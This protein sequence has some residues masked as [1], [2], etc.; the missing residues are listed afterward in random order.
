MPGLFAAPLEVFG[1]VPVEEH[2][3]FP[4]CQAVF[5]AGE[6]Q[7]IHARLP[8]DLGG[9]NVQ[10]GHG[11]G[12]PGTV[13]VD[14]QPITIRYSS[15]GAKLVRCVDRAHLRRLGQAESLGLGVV[16]I[17]ALGDQVLDALRG[18]F[19]IRPIAQ[20]QLGAIG[21]IFWPA[22]FIRFDVCQFV[23]DHAVEGLTDGG[24]CQGV[25]GGTIEY[26]VDIAVGIE[27]LAQTI[28]R[29]GGPDILAVGGLVHPVRLRHGRPGLGA[30]STVVIAGELFG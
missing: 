1:E 5:G 18:E 25:G 15:Y 4:E 20:K 23:A 17:T 9:V 29:A 21:G 12:E 8:G 28:G 16:D 6:T 14:I 2:H 10:R 3:R 19:A 24:Q 11:V 7:H 30:D 27:Q 22:A 13:H 26:E